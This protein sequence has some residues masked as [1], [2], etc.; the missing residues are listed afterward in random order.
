MK[1][2]KE[3]SYKS[4]KYIYPVIFDYFHS[5]LVRFC[6]RNGIEY[7]DVETLVLEKSNLL[8]FKEVVKNALKELIEE[9]YEEPS[10]KL[11]SKYGS[12]YEKIFVDGILN[13]IYETI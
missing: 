9:C 13:L 6:H 1:M 12:R 5:F 10:H 2:I 3:I 8:D 11:R 7:L 4:D